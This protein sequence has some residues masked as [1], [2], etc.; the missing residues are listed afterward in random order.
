MQNH[1]N[2]SELSLY[3]AGE[4]RPATREQCLGLERAAVWEPENI[5]SRLA[6][7]YAGRPNAWADSLR[8]Q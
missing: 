4:V 7:H 2:H 3:I 1:L 5:E 8:L 6:D